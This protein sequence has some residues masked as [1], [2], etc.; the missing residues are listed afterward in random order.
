[1][2]EL[3]TTG[4][5][6]GR[7]AAVA[8]RTL[9]E[10][11]LVAWGVAQGHGLVLAGAGLR[12]LLGWPQERTAGPLGEVIAEGHLERVERALAEVGEGMTRLGCRMLRAGGTEFDAELDVVRADDPALPG[13]VVFTV[14]DAT[15]RRRAEAQLSYLAFLDPLTGLANRALFLDRLRQA[16]LGARRTGRPFGVLLCDL[17]GFKAVNDTHGHDVGDALLR[18]VGVRLRGV[19]R[20]TDT[21]ARLGGDEFALALST[22]GGIHAAALVA[23]RVVRSLERP[24]EV[25]GRTCQ[26]GVS[27]GVATFPDHG[28][29]LDGL[30]AAADG[31]MYAAKRAG[32][33]CF[34]VA[35][36]DRARPAVRA[37]FV[38]W[39]DARRVGV[40]VIDG[41]HEHLAGLI[42]QLG[43]DLKQG[44]DRDRLVASLGALVAYTEEHFATEERLCDAYDPRGGAHHA[45]AHRQLL[46]DLKS[47]SVG[48]D[49]KSMS[50]TMRYLCEWLVRHIDTYDRGLARALR[51][52]HAPEAS[53][54]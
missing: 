54:A 42:N 53:E 43:D 36:T 44:R 22:V 10:G 27:V 1:M 48:L 45:G 9:L 40:P 28:D 8:G 17:D 34:T 23:G 30:V 41:Q 31:A 26:V 25:S 15:E 21:V 37:V 50:L 18:E 2:D 3:T 33:R 5:G 29:D 7:F 14:T 4:Q 20:E 51:E 49:E 13:A 24:I 16:L 19:V 46:E 35:E 11:R 6:V 39:S 47:L 52:A 12:A 32:K 38:E